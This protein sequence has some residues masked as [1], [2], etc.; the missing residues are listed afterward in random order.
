MVRNNQNGVNRAL[1]NEYSKRWL[2]ERSLMH[3]EPDGSQGG[4]GYGPRQ[5]SYSSPYYDYQKAHEYY[6]QHK[7]LKGKTRSKS[8]LSDEGK[9]IY[10]VAEYNIKKEKEKAQESLKTTTQGQIDQIQAAITQLKGLADNERGKYKEAINARIQTLKDQL[11]NK[12]AQFKSEL[13][14]KRTDIKDDNT[15]ASD[16]AS[17]SKEKLSEKAKREKERNTQNAQTKIEKKQAQIKATKD[18]SQKE[19]LRKDIANIRADKGVQNAQISSD[20]ATSKAGVS[21]SLKDYKAKNSA[22]LANY[23][24]SNAAGVKQATQNINDSI[25]GVRE[26]LKTYNTDSRSR[27]KGASD[28]LRAHIKELRAANQANRKILNEKYKEIQNQEFDR[29]YSSYAKK[30]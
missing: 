16:T 5:N 14:K 18:A 13:E 30:K 3:A 8:Q 23:R 15:R 22:E 20:L 27:Q 12:K 7:S 29:I 11:A 9:Q 24:A 2:M 1:L 6:E 19:S 21:S 26:E 17:K 4:K 10:E 25:K 28:E